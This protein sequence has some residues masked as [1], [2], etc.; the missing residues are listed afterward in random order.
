VNNI[1]VMRTVQA[2]KLGEIAIKLKPWGIRWIEI[3]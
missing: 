1:K 3:E 2:D